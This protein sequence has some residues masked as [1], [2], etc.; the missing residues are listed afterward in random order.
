MHIEDFCGSH[1][2]MAR[3]IMKENYDMERRQIP[4]L[5]EMA[6]LPELEYFAGAGLGVA[7]VEG[8]ELIGYLCAYSPRDDAFGTTNV[9]GTFVPVHAH[10][11]AGSITGRDRERI[12]SRMYQAAAEKWV[13]LGIRSHAIAL[14]THDAAAEK[15]FFYNGFGLRCID[16]IRSLDSIPSSQETPFDMAGALEYVE[17]LRDEWILLTELNNGLIR[18]L[19]DSPT[20]M[21]F[22]VTDAKELYQRAGEDTRYFAVKH[23]GRLAAYVKLADDGENFITES[24]DMINIC[25][26]YCEPEYRGSGIYHNL[27]CHVM[28]T[29][30]EEGYQRLGVDCESFNPNALGFW[31]KYF[32]EYTHGMVRRI[33]EK[34]VEEAVGR[35]A[36]RNKEDV[37]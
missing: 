22:P 20:F 37:N 32:T 2:K 31:T 7:A 5:P 13:R 3:Q 19:C 6:E 21:Y 4:E 29:V 26:A 15:S 27:L 8:E 14:Y 16:L 12:Y 28:R 30:K 11:V 23:Q 17:L 36:V 10:G 24:M 1:L 25:G 35:E 34:A 9:R 33:D 18:H